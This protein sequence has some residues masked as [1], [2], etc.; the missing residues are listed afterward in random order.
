M[1]LIDHLSFILPLPSCPSWPPLWLLQV[2]VRESKNCKAKLWEEA[3]SRTFQI[4]FTISSHASPLSVSLTAVFQPCVFTSFH[5]LDS[6]ASLFL[7]LCSQKHSCL[8]LL[9][10]GSHFHFQLILPLLFRSCHLCL[11]S[12]RTQ[13]QQTNLDLSTCCLLKL[14]QAQFLHVWDRNDNST[15]VKGFDKV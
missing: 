5:W 15:Y 3:I 8:V 12:Q 2:C 13:V 6:S 10:S 7:S 4:S 9:V 14:S 1:V 11:S